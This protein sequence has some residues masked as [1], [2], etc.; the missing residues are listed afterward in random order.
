MWAFLRKKRRIYKY[1]YVDYH[2]FTKTRS[3]FMNLRLWKRP[4]GRK[5]TY[6]IRKKM[7]KLFKRLVKIRRKKSWIKG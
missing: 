3:N 5:S 7:K 2:N 6:I 4:L 1:S